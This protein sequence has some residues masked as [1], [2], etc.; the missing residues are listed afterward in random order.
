MEVGRGGCD[1]VG[2]VVEVGWVGWY[3]LL[4]GIAG[5]WW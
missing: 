5:W 2:M 4:G 3:W 1:G